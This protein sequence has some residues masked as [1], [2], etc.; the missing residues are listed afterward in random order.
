MPGH[1]P[2]DLR[3]KGRIESITSRDDYVHDPW[4]VGLSLPDDWLHDVGYVVLL[5]S[6]SEKGSSRMPLRMGEN[7]EPDAL[8]DL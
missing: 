6:S 2:Y 1:S 7:W 5:G 4:T 8:E 3:M